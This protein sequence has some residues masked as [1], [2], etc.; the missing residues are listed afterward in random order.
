MRDHDPAL[1][2]AIREVATILG[3][4]LLRLRFLDPA[5]QS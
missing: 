1:D 2:D 4:A 5:S 3:D